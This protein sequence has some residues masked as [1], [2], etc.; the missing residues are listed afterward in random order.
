MRNRKKL[1]KIAIAFMAM[2]LIACSFNTTNVLACAEE[3]NV[4]R[5]SE[6]DPYEGVNKISLDEFFEQEDDDY[7]V[8]FYMVNCSYCNQVKEGM[9]DFASKNDVYFVDYLL[10][11]NRPTKKYDWTEAREKYNKKIGYINDIGEKVY[12]PGESEEKYSNMKNMYGKK[13]YFEFITVTSDNVHLY[14]DAQIGDIYTNVLTPEINYAAMEDYT[15]LM[16]P[17]VPIL[18]HISNDKIADFYFDSV[19]IAE[20]LNAYNGEK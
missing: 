19:D 11:N 9:L 14:P 4:R 16:I 8:Y 1:S 10:R 2:V 12:L 7:Y 6:S 13:M 3:T 5:L 18:F 17:G 15:E 20:F